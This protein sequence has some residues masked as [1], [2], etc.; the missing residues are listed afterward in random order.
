MVQFT[1]NLRQTRAKLL[2]RWGQVTLPITIF[3]SS[4]GQLRF[5]FCVVHYRTFGDY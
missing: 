4:S 5:D 1:G 2:D 3:N